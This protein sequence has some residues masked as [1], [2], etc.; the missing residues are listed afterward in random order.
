MEWIL[1]YS[2]KTQ[3]YEKII[4]TPSFSLIPYV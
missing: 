4:C 3:N 1:I 2:F